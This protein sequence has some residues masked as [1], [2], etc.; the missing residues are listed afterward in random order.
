MGQFPGAASVAGAA[1][2]VPGRD[3]RRRE[4]ADFD[5]VV[6]AMEA[7]TRAQQR[8]AAECDPPL[9]TVELYREVMGR[10]RAGAGMSASS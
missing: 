2:V 4:L 1:V 10:R 7:A 8:V 5:G 3:A 6:R 9:E